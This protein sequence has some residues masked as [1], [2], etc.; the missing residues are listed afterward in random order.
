VGSTET[1]GDVPVSDGFFTV[2]LDFGPGVFDGDARWLEV[3]VRQGSSVGDYTTLIPRQALTAAPYAQFSQNAGLLD[4]L[5][6]TDFLLTSGGT[7][8]GNLNVM[9]DVGIGTTSPQQKLHVAG[10]SRFD[11]TNGRVEVSSPG[12]WPGIIA[13]TQNGNRRDLVF[14]HDGLAILTSNSPD[15][16]PNES[17]IW[18]LENGDVG[19]GTWGPDRKLTVSASGSVFQNVKNGTQEILMGVDGTGGIL[20]VMTNH[21][22]ILRAG[23]DS[24]KMRI[25]AGGNVGIGT[26]DPQQKL[27]VAGVSQ[28]DLG[29]GQVHISTPG[30]WPGLIAFTQ[31][32]HRRDI[33]F[34][35]DAL[36]LLTSDSDAAPP[37]DSGIIIAEDGDVGIGTWAPAAKLDVNG[38]ARTEVLQITGGSDLAEPF[39]VAGAE[40]I[41]PGMLVA[42]DPEHAGQLR[43]ADKAY[44]RTVAGCVSG[45][46]GVNPGLT[47]QQEGTAADGQFP[48][49]LVGRVYCWATA[50]NGPIEPGDLLTTSDLPGYAMKV[51]NYS[52]A[53]GAT[54]GKAMSGLEEGEGLI[55]VLVT[56]Q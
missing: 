19:I 43:L 44:D 56:L 39:E 7:V 8:V 9:G 27:H 21:D 55:L 54:I 30:G 14:R 37:N 18:I 6:S 11:V 1:I 34:K 5:N 52:Q 35:N 48:V 10:V 31:N 47:M 3:A 26:N 16:P 41:E 50:A 33:A 32:G 28:F 23:G 40:N 13:F 38:T 15:A 51:A 17:G 2:E 4:Y 20:S 53:Q 29:T 45:A 22:L 25:K 36:Y 12:S 42:I 24:E 46:N 49:A